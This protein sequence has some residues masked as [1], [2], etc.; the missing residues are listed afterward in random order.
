MTPTE[1]KAILSE[2]ELQMTRA[3][4]NTHL[5]DARGKVA[6]GAL[7]IGLKN[8]YALDWV[9]ERLS[10]TIQ[11]TASAVIGQALPIEY[12]IYTAADDIP[13]PKAPHEPLAD[14][15]PGIRLDDKNFFKCPRFFTDVVASRGTGSA[16]KLYAQVLSE[17]VGHYDKETRTYGR[18]WWQD[19]TLAYLQPVT[20]LSR[21]AI[22]P[23]VHECRREGWLKW[24]VT[25]ERPKRFDLALR[26]EGEPVDWEEPVDNLGINTP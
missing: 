10:D 21:N 13:A 2:L 11:R 16:V 5:K 12:F 23:A 1:W 25:A 14:Y 7:R 20:G 6:E 18:E 19:L 17:T 15:I 26:V 24:R 3:T 9:Q 22:E 8:A 4:F